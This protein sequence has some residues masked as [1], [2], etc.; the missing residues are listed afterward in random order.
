[1]PA[2]PDSTLRIAQTVAA[3]MFIAE[4]VVLKS[5]AVSGVE[6]HEKANVGIKPQGKFVDVRARQVYSL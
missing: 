1:L 6:V 4:M 2:L 5:S 3:S